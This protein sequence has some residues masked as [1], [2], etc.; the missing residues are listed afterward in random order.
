MVVRPAMMVYTRGHCGGDRRRSQRWQIWRDDKVHKNSVKPDDQQKPSMLTSIR[1]HKSQTVFCVAAWLHVSFW[2]TVCLLAGNYNLDHITPIPSRWLP[3]YEMSQD[4]T[5]S[6]QLES[7]AH[8][9]TL[10]LS[11]WWQL[12][13]LCPVFYFLFYF[14]SLFP[15]LLCSSFTW[16]LVCFTCVLY[17]NP[18]SAYSCQIVLYLVLLPPVFDQFFLL[19][20]FLPAPCQF[21]HLYLYVVSCMSSYLLLD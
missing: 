12:G 11:P 5:E 15:I 16:L 13:G 9:Y 17:V 1:N 2:A 7:K 20:G 21:G 6:H 14:E 3:V 4:I 10:T 18:T 19:S 8:F